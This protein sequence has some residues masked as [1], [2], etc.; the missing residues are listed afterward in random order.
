MNK[1]IDESFKQDYELHY[2]WSFIKR[3][4]IKQSAFNGIDK[5]ILNKINDI[6]DSS[7]KD[8]TIEDYKNNRSLVISKLVQDLKVI[9]SWNELD[10]IISEYLNNTFIEVW[11]GSKELLSLNDKIKEQTDG[12]LTDGILTNVNIEKL[13]YEQ[14]LEISN[15]INR[16]LSSVL[17][18]YRAENYL[19]IKKVWDKTF[20]RENYSEGRYTKKL[21]YYKW[22]ITDKTIEIEY[23]VNDDA[24]LREEYKN[25][26]TSISLDSDFPFKNAENRGFNRKIEL[27]KMIKDLKIFPENANYYGIIDSKTYRYNKKSRIL[28]S[29]DNELFMWEAVITGGKLSDGS[30][31]KVTYLEMLEEIKLM[32]ESNGN[33]GQAILEE[34]YFSKDIIKNDPFFQKFIS[35][36]SKEYEIKE[37]A[38]KP[39]L[40]ENSKHAQNIKNC[41]EKIF[42]RNDVSVKILGKYL[43]TSDKYC[44]WILSE[45]EI[46]K[47]KKLFMWAVWWVNSD[48]NISLKEVS[49]KDA[50]EMQRWLNDFNILDDYFRQFDKK[51]DNPIELEHSW[52]INSDTRNYPLK[53]EDPIWWIIA[54]TKVMNS[55]K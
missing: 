37:L 40:D 53:N 13:K 8:F 27:E 19:Y 46:D 17:W 49:S 47:E 7:L 12:I 38:Y 14:S 6:I 52:K 48:I 22:V 34:Y 3:K 5:D 45:I 15:F 2:L 42:N 10:R 32:P 21:N 29:V 55:L 25:I 43:T 16:Y 11:E 36:D 30:F 4:I 18:L 28:F 33:K 1:N 44:F 31:K 9:S 39:D 41:V 24:G 35:N 26:K 50:L 23:V 51:I 54:Y 20:F